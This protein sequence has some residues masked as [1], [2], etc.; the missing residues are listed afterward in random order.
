MIVSKS[1]SVLM[2]VSPVF[3]FRFICICAEETVKMLGRC[4]FKALLSAVFA[5]LSA[6]LV[7][8]DQSVA[9][10]EPRPA[11]CLSTDEVD[12]EG[13]INKIR[14]ENKLPGLP[15]SKPLYM[16]AKWH[17]IDLALFSPHEKKDSKGNSCDLHSWS[18]KGAGMGGWKPLCYTADHKNA[19][20][21]FRKP[22][23]IANYMSDG[24]ENI[25]WTSALLTPVMVISGWENRKDEKDIILQQ[26][27]FKGNRW[28]S[29]GVGIYGNYASVWF[30][31]GVNNQG[32]M[33]ACEKP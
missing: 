27:N 16:V 17:V 9:P 10:F 28:T 1:V 31:E 26:G 33:S 2:P 6:D 18:D 23:E 20:D 25:Y 22:Y 32:E 8:A 30:A 7:C 4:C 21:M 19:V 29:M 3:P 5:L 24:Y 15:V 12:L 11:T 13:R 14:G